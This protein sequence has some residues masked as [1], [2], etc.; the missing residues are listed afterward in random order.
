M[1]DSPDDP[2]TGTT[3]IIPD[4]RFEDLT[5][6]LLLPDGCILVADGSC[7]RV[8]SADLQKMI[9][10]AGNADEAG[11][12]DGMSAQARFNICLYDFLLLADG[13]VLVTDHLNN[14][15]RLLSADLRDVTTVAG[16]G[17]RG[18]LDGAAAQA[19]FRGPM[20]LALLPDGCVLVTDYFNSCIRMLSADLQQVSTVARDSEAAQALFFSPH[21]L[22]VLPGGRVLVSD[23][24]DHSISM[25]SADLQEM[26]TVA[27]DGAEGHIDG[28]AIQAEFISPTDLLVLF[29]YRVLVST[30]NS[31]VRIISADFQQ[32]DTVVQPEQGVSPCGLAQ[33]PDGRVLVSNSNKTFTMLDGFPPSA[34]FRRRTLLMSLIRV[35]AVAPPADV[36]DDSPVG[37]MDDVLLRMAALPANV[38]DDSPVGAMDDVLLRMAALPEELWRGA[39]IFQYL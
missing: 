14:S 10:V 27:G 9:T 20:G 36:A 22:A 34:W 1:D 5:A 16:D 12:Q 32:V 3:L 21:N 7:I 38:A 4:A 11:N 29:D 24:N 18:Y 39:H 35:N 28:A 25:L 8:I 31:G 17:R 26:R 15:I 23:Y 33:L 19:Q 30:D 2:I 13:C 37:A 6:L